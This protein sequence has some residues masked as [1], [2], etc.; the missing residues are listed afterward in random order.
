MKRDIHKQ[1]E[2]GRKI[3]KKHDMSNLRG[4]EIV[5]LYEEFKSLSLEKPVF[6]AFWEKIVDAFMMGVT[7][8][9]NCEKRRAKA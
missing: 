5:E 8:G 9:T 4:E 1:A 3:M 2:L 7:V 6:D